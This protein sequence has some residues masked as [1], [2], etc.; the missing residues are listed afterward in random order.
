[1]RLSVPAYSKWTRCQISFCELPIQID[2][3]GFAFESV[4]AQPPVMRSG[5]IG[6][7]FLKNDVAFVR[8]HEEAIDNIGLSLKYF[9]VAEQLFAAQGVAFPIS[10]LGG[11]SIACTRWEI[12]L[13]TG[14][15]TVAQAMPFSRVLKKYWQ[16]P[17]AHW[18]DRGILARPFP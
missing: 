8:Q 15:S 11:T 2:I 17:L 10:T 6:S 3:S 16:S 12:L 7:S 9:G 14:P 18:T 1:M 4:I 13:L 5:V